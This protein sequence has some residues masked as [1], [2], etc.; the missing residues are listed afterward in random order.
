MFDAATPKTDIPAAAPPAARP[1]PQTDAYAA[2]ARAT[3]AR[4]FR[5]D[6][7]CGEALVLQRPGLRLVTR[8][9]LWS[10]TTSPQDARRALRRLARFPGALIA[11]PDTPLSGPGLLPLVTG[12]HVALW[13]L[14][15]DLRA[16]MAGKWRNR[17]AAAEGAGLQLHRG[18]PA[19][20]ARLVAAEA[21]QARIRG[22]RGHPPAFSLAL[23]RES[24]RLWEWRHGGEMAAAMAFVTEGAGAWWH[25]SWAG[26]AARARGIPGLML[27]R[28]AAALQAEGIRQL[29]LGTLSDAAPGLMRFK[30][31]TG[32]RLR[33]LGAT[34][35]VLPG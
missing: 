30:L 23:P 34:C 19:T 24:L 31:G 28:A 25:L 35:L 5:A 26:E 32:A 11:T 6:L 17:L 14:T 29:D 12:L 3:G 21:A 18:G 33:R 13:E 20:L 10:A 9:P 1:F 16:G 4:A 7:G 27:A 22:Y 8:G 15:G 2:A